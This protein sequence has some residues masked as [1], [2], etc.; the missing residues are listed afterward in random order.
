VPFRCSCRCCTTRWHPCA[1]NPFPR[2]FEKERFL[3]AVCAAYWQ[4]PEAARGRSVARAL[5]DKLDL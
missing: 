5:L 2:Y 1:S 4:L 3:Q